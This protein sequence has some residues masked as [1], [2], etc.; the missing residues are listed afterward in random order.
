MSAEKFPNIL[1]RQMEATAYINRSSEQMQQ[2][3]QTNQQN[4]YFT[5]DLQIIFF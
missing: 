1:S 4:V 2:Q 3:Q 5:P